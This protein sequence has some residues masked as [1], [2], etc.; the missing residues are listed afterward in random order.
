MFSLC[1]LNRLIDMIDEY[2]S[3]IE[4]AILH[5]SPWVDI[6]RASNDIYDLKITKTKLLRLRKDC[7]NGDECSD[8]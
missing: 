2:I 3:I 1:E 8:N 6:Y 4:A 5:N 7:I